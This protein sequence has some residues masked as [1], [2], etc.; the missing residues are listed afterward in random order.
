[1]D[2]SS[3]GGTSGVTLSITQGPTQPL[4]AGDKPPNKSIPLA[5]TCQDDSLP[6]IITPIET[7][8]KA[9]GLKNGVVTLSLSP[10]NS[11]IPS[12]S[13]A[14]LLPSSPQLQVVDLGDG[15]SSESESTKFDEAT[16]K[17]TK[18]EK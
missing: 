18:V 4:E 1:M 7:K 9:E 5:K 2:S 15:G 16:K 17:T 14:L 3:Q 6:I 12:I 10:H 8:K 13:V 11:L